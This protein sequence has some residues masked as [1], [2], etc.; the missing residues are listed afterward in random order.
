MRILGVFV[1]CTFKCLILNVS[2][3]QTPLQ[4]DVSPQKTK[5]F[6]HGGDNLYS[7]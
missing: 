7:L 2:N 3:V 1:S 6:K 4:A 5:L